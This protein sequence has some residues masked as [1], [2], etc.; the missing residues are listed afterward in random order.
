VGGG[1]RL[2]VGGH[3]SALPRGEGSDR[4]PGRRA[5]TAT[6]WW[7]ERRHRSPQMGDEHA[8]DGDSNRHLGVGNA[9]QRQGRHSTGQRGKLQPTAPDHRRRRTARASN[10]AT[11]GVRL[12]PG[13]PSTPI[14]R[15]RVGCPGVQTATRRRRPAVRRLSDQRSRGF[16]SAP[17]RVVR[18]WDRDGGPSATTLVERRKA[19]SA[20][21]TMGEDHRADLRLVDKSP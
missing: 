13:A 11:T 10:A 6:A 18:A 17:L 20:V 2:N 8:E 7:R 12:T 21:V 1:R 15:V 16:S 19:P 9:G 14:S 4:W 3:G 5:R